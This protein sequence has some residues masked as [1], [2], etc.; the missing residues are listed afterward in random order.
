[1]K[2]YLCLALAVSAYFLG[3]QNA[4]AQ[5]A[6]CESAI[7]K[8]YEQAGQDRYGNASASKISTLNYYQTM[9]PGSHKYGNNRALFYLAVIDKY[10]NGRMAGRSTAKLYC[11][12]D[13]SG[14]VLGLER[15]F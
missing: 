7:K 6:A 4:S 12:I 1:M 2:K 10:D 8:R 5:S 13:N 11:V 15:Q 14:K 9:P 3:I